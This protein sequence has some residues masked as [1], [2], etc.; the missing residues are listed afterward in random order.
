MAAL[1]T[2]PS[3]EPRCPAGAPTRPARLTLV[4]A[5]VAG[6]G[7]PPRVSAA[8]YR[9]RRVVCALGAV[10]VAVLLVVVAGQAGAALGSSPLEA[11]GRPPAVTRYVV[12][13]G[14]SLWTVARRVA[15]DRDPRPIVDA[16]A[17]ARHDAP[18]LP[19]ETIVWQK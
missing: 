12:K 8:T 15:P 13:S 9:R 10:L 2:T 11:A 5:P 17:A 14:D 6:A 1:M 3:P 16:L 4:P 7:R 18:L 19:G